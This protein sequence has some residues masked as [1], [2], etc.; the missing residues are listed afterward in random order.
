MYHKRHWSVIFIASIFVHE[1]F[2][3]QLLI[4]HYKEGVRVENPYHNS[5]KCVKIATKNY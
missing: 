5:R 3:K 4:H 1:F 2:A